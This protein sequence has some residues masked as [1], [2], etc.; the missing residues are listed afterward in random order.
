[1]SEDAR[2]NKSVIWTPDTMR[3]LQVSLRSIMQEVDNRIK[4]ALSSERRPREKDVRAAITVGYD[5]LAYDGAGAED[6]GAYPDPPANTFWIKLSH[7]EYEREEGEQDLTVTPYNPPVYRL[8]RSMFGEYYEEGTTVWVTLNHGQ[9]FIMP[10][11]GSNVGQGRFQSFIYD[12]DEEN[13]SANILVE[14]APCSMPDLIGQTIEVTDHSQCIFDHSEEDLYDVWVWFGEGYT[15]YLGC[16]WVAHDRCCVEADGN[17]DL[18]D[19][20]TPET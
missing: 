7:P 3:D 1:M 8:A 17:L 16:H 10:R 12:Y 6:P 18:G 14:V 9:Y 11:G 13:L 2:Q 5:P 15:D 19:E 20:L 4:L